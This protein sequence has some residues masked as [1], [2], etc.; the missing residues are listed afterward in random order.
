MVTLTASV[1]YDDPDAVKGK[2]TGRI[3]AAWALSG[4]WRLLAS[5]GQGFKTPSI[6]QAVCDFCFA[7][8][9][10]L[11]PETAQGYDLGAAWASESGRFGFDLDAYQLRVKD[12]IAYVASRYINIA[13]VKSRGIEASAHADLGAGLALQLSYALTDAI[14]DS[15]GARLVRV[16]VTTASGVLTYAR[17][18]LSG[19]LTVRGESSQSDI[20]VNSA[21][22]RRKGFVVG[23]LAGAYALNAAVSFTARIENLTGRHYQE[24]SGY[25]EPGRAFYVGLRL[26]R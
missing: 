19:A 6:P 13:R 12:Q 15:T 7:P 20:D 25:G 16:P 3:S 23:D 8:A 4:G 21:P 2:A 24:V 17:G 5:A 11:K 9:A 22:A 10:P 1:R 14:D 18:P 26:R